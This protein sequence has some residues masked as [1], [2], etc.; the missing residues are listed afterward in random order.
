MK[1]IRFNLTR[2]TRTFLNCIPL[3]KQWVVAQFL[4]L[5]KICDK[6]T[7]FTKPYI[8]TKSFGEVDDTLLGW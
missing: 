8:L 7:W 2:A 6:N 3:S 5:R 4:L 1:Y